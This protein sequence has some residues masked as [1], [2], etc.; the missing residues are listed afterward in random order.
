MQDPENTD[1]SGPPVAV[2]A[3][4]ADIKAGKVVE[5]AKEKFPDFVIGVKHDT[6]RKAVVEAAAREK[7]PPKKDD[8]ED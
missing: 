1:R 3:V 5:A 7:K 4:C 8:T 2:C 6:I